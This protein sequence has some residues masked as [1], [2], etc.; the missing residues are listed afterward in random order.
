MR[1]GL[2]PVSIPAP[3]APSGPPAIEVTQNAPTDEALKELAKQFPA[4]AKMVREAR[5][6]FADIIAAGGRVIVTA[7]PANGGQPVAVVMAPGFDPSKPARV[8]THYHGDLAS[9][10]SLRGQGTRAIKAMLLADPTRV[11]VV[12]EA[13][14]NVG[15]SPTDWG[16][17]VSQRQT[18]ADALLAANIRSVGETT[19]SAHSAGGR[20]LARALQRDG[21]SAQRIVLIDCLY[22]G[23]DEDIRD[24]LQRYG[25]DVREIVVVRGYN[26]RARWKTMIETFPKQAK[27]LE[28]DDY[29]A[30]NAH[31]AALRWMM[32]G[33]DARAPAPR[34]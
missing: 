8:H 9:A 26:E 31:F 33:V 25:K 4:R 20:A 12:P 34:S 29:G 15:G 17:V 6:A 30:D 19:V 7:S 28:I 2:S 23:A 10:V 24:G 5:Q 3:A 1:V 14:D 13:Q 32:D 22:K 16:N 11:F 27:G 18:T 21:V